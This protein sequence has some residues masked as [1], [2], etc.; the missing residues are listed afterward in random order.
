MIKIIKFLR[1]NWWDLFP[2]VIFIIV[3][4]GE[5]TLYW[6][7]GISTII[8]AFTLIVRHLMKIGDNVG[9]PKV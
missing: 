3:A 9:P 5:G 7:A 6:V 2:L 8:W 1:T 4:I